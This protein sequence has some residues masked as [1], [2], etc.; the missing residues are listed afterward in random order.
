L[1]GHRALGTSG[2]RV[3]SL[4]LGAMT[5][6]TSASYQRITASDDE[7]LRILDTALDM[8]I[9]VV[10]TANAYSEGR[11]E[12]LVGRWLSGKRDRV[13]IATKCRFP[14]H[15]TQPVGRDEYGLSR[16]AILRACE[17]SLRRL[18]TDYI[19]LFQLHMQDRSV[20]IEETL[21][22]LDDLV[23][24][25]KIRYTGLS[26]FT[27][28]RMVQAAWI[29]ERHNVHRPTSVQLPWSLVARDIER[30][31]L[32]AARMLELGVMVYSPL[33]RGFLSGKY[34]RGTAPPSDSRLAA[35]SDQYRDYDQPHHWR[36]LDALRAVAA[37]QEASPSAVALAWTLQKRG[38]STVIVGA[39]S[40]EQLR[41]NMAAA[42]LVLTKAQVAALD[43]ASV[44]EWGYPQTFIGRHEP[45]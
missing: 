34:H 16:S 45:W 7:A 41:E 23:R 20:P 28:Y 29:A 37:E 8:G 18:G 4:S 9:D 32:P 6:G 2:L 5:F 26:N 27:A 42:T 33:G 35:W 13:V 19:D 36:A 22:A 21:R 1:I 31:L 11:S 43:A 40:V 10:D 3:S 30:E 17:S 38:V 44:P 25:G 14:T 24:A 15:A 12:E 39:R